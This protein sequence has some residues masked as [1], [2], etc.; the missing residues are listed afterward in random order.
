MVLKLEDIREEDW[1]DINMRRR[2]IKSPLEGT[3]QEFDGVIDIIVTV[4]GTNEEEKFDQDILEATQ[5]TIQ[6]ELIPQKQIS[7]M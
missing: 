2:R 1:L 5:V 6:T 3:W 7:N 4:A